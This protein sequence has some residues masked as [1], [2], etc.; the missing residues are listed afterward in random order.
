VGENGNDTITGGAGNDILRGGSGG[1]TGDGYKDTFVFK[2]GDDSD[3]IKDFENDRDQL[4]VT[5]FALA[6]F[7]ALQAL[8]SD[9]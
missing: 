4:D 6:D 1:S 7:A 3:T 2:N 5:D 8:A 9:R